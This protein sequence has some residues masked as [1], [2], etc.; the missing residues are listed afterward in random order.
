[1]LWL[2]PLLPLGLA[3]A[4]YCWWRSA[5]RTTVVTSVGILALAFSGLVA[6]AIGLQWQ[7]VLPWNEV[8][9]LQLGLTPA[10]AA[11]ALVVPLVAAPILVYAAAQEPFNGLARL[12]AFLVG[13]V[14]AMELLVLAKDLLTLLI[15]WEIVGAFSWALIGHHFLDGEKTRHAAQAFLTTRSGDLGLYLAAFIAFSQTGGLDYASL[16]QLSG[17][18]ASVFAAG[19]LLAVASKSAQIPFSPWLFSAMSGPAPVSALLHSATMVAAGV[20]L[21]VQLHPVLAGVGWFGPAV[22]TI[23][24]VTA[25][26]GSLVAITSPHGKRLLAGSTSAHYGFMF[27]SLGAGYPIA[28]ILHFVAH[29]VMKGPLFLVV[30]LSGDK[31][32]SYQL[33]ALGKTKLPKGLMFATLGA[34]LALAGLFPLGAGWTKESIVTAA[35]HFAPWTALATALAGGLSAV[36]AAR[37]MLSL[38]PHIRSGSVQESSAKQEAERVQLAAIYALVLATLAASLLWIP[39]ISHQVTGW[40]DSEMPPF[41]TTELAFSM[42]LVVGGLGIGAWLGKREQQATSQGSLAGFISTWMGLPGVA[43]LL[44]ARPLLH[45]AHTLAAL[46]DRAVDAGV[47]ATAR[48]AER[49]GAVGDRLGEWLFDEIPEGLARVSGY[50][51]QQLRALQSGMLHHYYFVIAGGVLAIVITLALETLAGGRL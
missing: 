39:G 37:L 22:L 36:Y 1:M 11:F 46:D 14:G 5:T 21:L 9:R 26:A 10:S 47:M 3:P 20:I 40:L 7:G 33:K 44:I 49:A 41:K 30:G 50:A 31:A 8:L 2:V 23:G 19:I 24:L 6:L 51:G 43:R 32:D 25:F 45:V 18:A 34:T 29:A 42:A 13:F 4:L 27:V 38:F 28:A 16:S 48:L 35:G 17:P 12:M 15:A